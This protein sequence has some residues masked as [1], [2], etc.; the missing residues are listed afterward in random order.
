[1]SIV[2]AEFNCSLY[3]LLLILGCKGLQVEELW[4]LEEEDFNRLK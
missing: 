1:M 3:V 2:I 4:S